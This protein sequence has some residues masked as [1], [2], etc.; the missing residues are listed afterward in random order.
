M[1]DFASFR[2]SAEMELD[3]YSELLGFHTSSIAPGEIAAKLDLML[4]IFDTL[5]RLEDEAETWANL[6]RDE[7]DKM[8]L[9][10]SAKADKYRWSEEARFYKKVCRKTSNAGKK[11][12]AIQSRCKFYN[13]NL[14]MGG[15]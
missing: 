2:D 10:D 7:I 11:L 13:Q 4:S 3:K 12:S 15:V 5:E 14:N 9:T 8:E 1:N 6:K